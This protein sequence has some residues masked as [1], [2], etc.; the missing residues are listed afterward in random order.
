MFYLFKL[1]IKDA[2]VLKTIEI[3]SNVRESTKS[4]L[5]LHNPLP[6]EIT[7]NEKDVTLNSQNVFVSSKFPLKLQSNFDYGLE[8]TY[9]PLIEQDRGE[10]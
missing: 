3:S 8:I 9:R 2:D 5:L 10:D 6:Q 4:I 1:T 7:I